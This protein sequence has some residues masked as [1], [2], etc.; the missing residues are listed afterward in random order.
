MNMPTLQHVY[1]VGEP[2]RNITADWAYEYFGSKILANNE[3]FVCRL[4]G[5][6]VGLCGGDIQKLHF[7]HS[8]SG[9]DIECTER[10]L[11][12]ERNE[13]N[14]PNEIKVHNNNCFLQQLPLKLNN[15]HFEIGFPYIETDNYSE[16][17]YIILRGY[18]N[19]KIEQKTEQKTKQY[20]FERLNSSGI[21]YLSV[22]KKIVPFYEILVTN[23]KINKFIPKYIEGIYRDYTF[24]DFDTGKKIPYDGDIKVDHT[25][26]LLSIIYIENYYKDSIILNHKSFI[27]NY[28][29]YEFKVIN[30]NDEIKN[31]IYN[32][33]SYNLQ[34]EELFN[35]KE[36]IPLWP[37]YVKRP[38]FI[39]ISKDN[40]RLYFNK[41]NIEYNLYPKE[42][43]SSIQE[44]NLNLLCNYNLLSFVFLSSSGFYRDYEFLT[45]KKKEFDRIII[46][47]SNVKVFDFYFKKDEREVFQG[48]HN[49]LPFKR[50]LS[51]KNPKFDGFWEIISDNGFVKY[52]KEF[53]AEEST[54]SIN[55]LDFGDTVNIYYGFDLVWSAKYEKKKDDKID[56]EKL[57]LELQKLTGKKI[58]IS[59]SIASIAMKMNLYPK[60][61]NWFLKQIRDGFILDKAFYKLKKNILRR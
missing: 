13:K 57:Y 12:I 2:S 56:D 55:D 47:S 48:I 9:A 53:K 35:N 39:D 40:D 4:C 54:T 61:K 8:R 38:Y 43:A 21:T 15:D 25:Y 23:N 3:V 10:A 6:K 31:F 41:K 18:N 17:F 22:G 34:K 42:S 16:L 52:K 27:D 33:Y 11:I 58:S 37:S 44:N 19:Q 45:I 51:L 28:F 1:W 5:E 50:K 26:Y 60:T 20:S 30:Y 32:S 29:L 46:D 24:F 7:R 36:F 14:I 49:Q 59:H